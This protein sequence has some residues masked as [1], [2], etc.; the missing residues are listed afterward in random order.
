MA[1]KPREFQNV[2]VYKSQ[3]K[4]SWRRGL[5][6]GGMSNHYDSYFSK[7]FAINPQF[8]IKN[9]NKKDCKCVVALS[10]ATLGV[11]HEDLLSIGKIWVK[12][13]YNQYVCTLSSTNCKMNISKQM[14]KNPYSLMLRLKF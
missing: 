3:F 2:E 1:L 14:L 8:L 9:D 5:N 13:S 6:A 10:Q 12:V 4:G 7:K 11:K